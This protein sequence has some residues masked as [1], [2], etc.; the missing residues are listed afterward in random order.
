M[1]NGTWTS[2][3]PWEPCSETCGNEGLQIRYR[4]CYQY[5]C[6]GITDQVRPCK[7][8]KPCPTNKGR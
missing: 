2:W 4:M 5:G 3:G 6:K 1:K 8:S 7:P